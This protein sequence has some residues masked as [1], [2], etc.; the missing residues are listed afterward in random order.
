MDKRLSI[1][2]CLLITSFILLSFCVI[3]IDQ[4]IKNQI[5]LVPILIQTK[6]NNNDAN[7]TF[8]LSMHETLLIFYLEKN[9]K[10]TVPLFLMLQQNGSFLI[11][12]NDG[13]FMKPDFKNHGLIFG[14]KEKGEKMI[15]K[16]HHYGIYHMMTLDTNDE[17]VTTNYVLNNT[18][19]H[20]VTMKSS[21]FTNTSIVD[22]VIVPRFSQIYS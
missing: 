16:E 19:F 18:N 12:T 21:N 1:S 17:L 11:L 13:Y 8:Y 22:F 10:N 7:E 4:L 3:L 6:L 14:S 9:I 2:Y 20:I 5:E 15:L